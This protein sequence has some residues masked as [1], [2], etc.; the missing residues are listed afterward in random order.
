LLSIVLTLSPKSFSASKES[1]AFEKYRNPNTK[2]QG[3]GVGFSAVGG[4]GKRNIEAE[5]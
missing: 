1:V 3:L 4:S 2:L 5:T